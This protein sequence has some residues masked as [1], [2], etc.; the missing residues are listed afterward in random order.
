MA[1][2]YRHTGF[3]YGAN[4]PKAE[5]QKTLQMVRERSKVRHPVAWICLTKH[6]RS[7]WSQLPEPPPPTCVEGKGEGGVKGSVKGGQVMADKD[8][9]VSLAGKFEQEVKAWNTIG[10]NRESHH[11]GTPTLQK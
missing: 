8:E 4:L 6:R 7:R 5:R 3:S 10:N 9:R 1:C 2:L 11:T